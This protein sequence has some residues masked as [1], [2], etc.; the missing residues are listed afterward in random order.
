MRSIPQQDLIL[1]K[2]RRP[3]TR[4]PAYILRNIDPSLWARVKA[5]SAAEGV[6]LRAIIL[7]LL[8]FYAQ[9][10]LSIVATRLRS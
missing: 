10:A 6:P 9:G 7:K 1:N 4:M 2:S 5:R 8:E 3:T